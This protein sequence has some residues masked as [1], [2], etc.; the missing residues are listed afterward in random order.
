MSVFP[1]KNGTERHYPVSSNREFAL[2]ARE[3]VT[4]APKNS[5]KMGGAMAPPV[6]IFLRGNAPR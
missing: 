5:N 4:F 6:V 1:Q 3:S 2:I